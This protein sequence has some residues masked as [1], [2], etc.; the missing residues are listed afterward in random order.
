VPTDFTQCL[1]YMARTLSNALS[2][3]LE[4]IL[5]RHGLT[6]AQLG[7]LAQLAPGPAAGMSGAELAQGADVTAQSMSTAIASL[8]QRGLVDRTPHPTHGRVLQVRITDAGAD[9]LEQAQAA[10]RTVDEQALARLS[11]QERTELRELMHRVMD[12]L[13]LRTESPTAHREAQSPR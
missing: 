11:D 8:L 2:R 12:T 13:G 3:Q 10:T 4:R 5:G 6:H 1:P 9:L 7:A